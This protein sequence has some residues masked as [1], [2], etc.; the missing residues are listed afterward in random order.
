MSQ[1]KPKTPGRKVYYG[2]RQ[3]RNHKTSQPLTQQQVLV[4]KSPHL[5][6]QPRLK[7]R[8]GSYKPEKIIKKVFNPNCK[9][10]DKVI[11]DIS[12]A[13]GISTDGTPV[14]FDCVLNLLNQQ[15]QLV[16]GQKIIYIGSGRFAVTPVGD[17]NSFVRTIDYEKYCTDDALL[18]RKSLSITPRFIVHVEKTTVQM[19]EDL[20]K[21]DIMK[22][23]VSS[24]YGLLERD[25]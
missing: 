8:P 25:N 9:I 2:R 24:Q 7:P 12:A 21:L 17:I 13:L 19:N 23:K 14:H 22:S 11:K 6:K 16:P 1:V 20:D 15:E 5:P 10:C 3:R 4:T 18:W